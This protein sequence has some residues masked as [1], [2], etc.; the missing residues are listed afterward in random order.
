M[1]KEKRVIYETMKELL[2]VVVLKMC[3][4]LFLL[5]FFLFS[6]IF[7]EYL[8]AEMSDG[9]MCDTCDYF[10]P[11]EE[12]IVVLRDERWY[13]VFTIL[14]NPKSASLM[15]PVLAMRTFSGLRSR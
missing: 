15:C 14:L 9:K 10:E 12:V 1:M 5:F 11:W 2:G 3:S 7:G 6:G 4:A 13:L 8:K